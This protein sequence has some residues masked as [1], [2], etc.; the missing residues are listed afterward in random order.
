M[1]NPVNIA[2][3]IAVAQQAAVAKVQEKQKDDDKKV[4]K[5]KAA[6]QEGDK[7]KDTKNTQQKSAPP[8]VNLDKTT[9]IANARQANAKFQDKL[10]SQQ[11]KQ[12]TDKLVQGAPQL[13]NQQLSSSS[14]KQ[15]FKDF[16]VDQV[17]VLLKGD[18]FKKKFKGYDNEL[19]TAAEEMLILIKKK[20]GDFKQSDIDSNSTLGRVL[21]TKEKLAKLVAILQNTT[22]HFMDETGKLINDPRAN[23]QKKA[24]VLMNI[25]Q[26]IMNA[27]KIARQ[28]QL[29]MS[30][31]PQYYGINPLGFA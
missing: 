18:E 15:G 17:I 16:A 1:V 10:E 12:L 31:V 30:V 14:I 11:G 20:Q 29:Y 6:T 27:E 7:S 8:G 25:S 5:K 23:S 13:K 28:E 2:R 22:D 9:I 26:A 19:F 4:D 21:L 3:T 24:Q